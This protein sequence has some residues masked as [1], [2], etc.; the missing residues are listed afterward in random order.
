M[1]KLVPIIVITCAVVFSGCSKKADTAAET[2]K[3]QSAAQVVIKETE[4]SE[5][6][7]FPDEISE[8]YDSFQRVNNEAGNPVEIKKLWQDEKD[9]HFFYLY[10]GGSDVQLYLDGDY[11]GYSVS[12]SKNDSNSDLKTIVQMT[13]AALENTK[14]NDAEQYM[15]TLLDSYTGKQD[16][17]PVY[18]SKYRFII[19]DPGDSPL[20]ENCFGELSAYR[21]ADYEIINRDNNSYPKAGPEFMQAA[22]NFGEKASLSGEVVKIEEGDFSV[23]LTVKKDE[24]K[25]LVHC[26]PEAFSG[27]FTEGESYIFYGVVAENT[28]GYDGTLRLV[29]YMSE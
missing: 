25:Y 18:R 17:K 1:K 5:G 14:F 3:E 22:I 19:L 23:M 24:Y 9:P 6:E 8:I 10:V 7:N 21:L 12:L 15:Q 13:V 2:T 20:F 27:D 11:H 29:N 4:S 16:G 28:D 26:S